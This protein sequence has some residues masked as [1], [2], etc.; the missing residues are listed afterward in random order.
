MSGENKKFVKLKVEAEETDC[1]L[2]DPNC[3]PFEEP[4]CSNM[5]YLAVVNSLFFWPM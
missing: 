5:Q 4:R 3:E 2:Y 1:P